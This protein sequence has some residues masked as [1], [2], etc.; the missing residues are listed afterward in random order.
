L[1]DRLSDYHLFKEYLVPWNKFLSIEESLMMMMMMMMM[2]MI[3]GNFDEIY[4]VQTGSGAH[5]AFHPMGTWGSFLG[6]EAA[7]A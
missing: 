1:F 4:R 7:G 2:M 3:T 5:P 6:G